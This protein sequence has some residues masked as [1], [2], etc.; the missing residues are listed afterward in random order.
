MHISH[1]T[2]TLQPWDQVWHALRRIPDMKGQSARTL[3]DSEISRFPG[4]HDLRAAT[5]SSI[6][7][8]RS[9]GHVVRSLVV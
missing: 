5:A 7:C 6:V 3:G 8:T 4:P 9:C 2:G 1:A